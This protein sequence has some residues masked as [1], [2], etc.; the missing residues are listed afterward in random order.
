MSAIHILTGVEVDRPEL[1]RPVLGDLDG[2]LLVL[3]PEMILPLKS[4]MVDDL[5][6]LVFIA[7]IQNVEEICAVNLS[8]LGEAVGEISPQQGIILVLSPKRL[9]GELRVVRDQYVLDLLHGEKFLL[10]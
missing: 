1:L 7:S 4:R 6:Q 10:L 8:A 9:D 3:A 5:L 2:L